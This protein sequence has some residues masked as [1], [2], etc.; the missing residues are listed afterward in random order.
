MN[1]IV[2]EIIF[3]IFGCCAIIFRSLL[4][5]YSVQ[6]Q[7]KMFGI[8]SSGLMIRL[9]A[10]GYLLFGIFFVATGVVRIIGRL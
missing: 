7:E 8:P 2:I 4:G 5:R 10:F 6:F 9:T 3:I 1:S